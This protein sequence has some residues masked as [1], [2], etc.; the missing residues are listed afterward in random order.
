MEDILQLTSVPGSVGP[1]SNASRTR[2]R[3]RSSYTARL[4]RYESVSYQLDPCTLPEIEPHTVF[5]VD[6]ICQPCGSSSFASRVARDLCPV[7]VL[8]QSATLNERHVESAI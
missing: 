2:P 1:P 6:S 3:I 5:V 8:N 4:S 7:C